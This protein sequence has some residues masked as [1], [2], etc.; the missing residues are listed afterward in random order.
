MVAAVALAVASIASP[1]RDAVE[2]LTATNALPAHLAGQFADRLVRTDAV[3]ANHAVVAADGKEFAQY[4]GAGDAA[5]LFR[6]LEFL[7]E[8]SGGDI[9]HADCVA[10]GDKQ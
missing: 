6:G 4:R 2:V 1:P 5:D 8:L 9:M 10:A 3:Q 7:Q